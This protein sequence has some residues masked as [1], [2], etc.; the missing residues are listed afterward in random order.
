M[1][2]T[3]G[4]VD[5]PDPLRA[6]TGMRMR[7]AAVGVC[8]FLSPAGQRE[9][10]ERTAA[11]WPGPRGGLLR[12]PLA[13]GTTGHASRD[14]DLWLRPLSPFVIRLGLPPGRARLWLGDDVLQA[15]PSQGLPTEYRVANYRK[16]STH[17]TTEQLFCE[18]NYY[19]LLL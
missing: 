5:G 8:P 14:V 3:D 2:E 11:R 18:E 7:A 15:P 6:L 19:V 4:Q 16:Q 10:L 13:H 17:D 9:I 12:R 1:Y